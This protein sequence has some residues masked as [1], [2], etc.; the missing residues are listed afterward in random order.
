MTLAFSEPH[1]RS[2]EWC[3][4]R[5]CEGMIRMCYENA[6]FVEAQCKERLAYVCRDIPQGRPAHVALQDRILHLVQNYVRS[7]RGL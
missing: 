6:S 7:R 2:C 4:R 3:E 1:L 5:H